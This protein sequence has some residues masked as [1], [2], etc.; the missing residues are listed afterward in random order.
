VSFL[1]RLP[2]KSN[3]KE[4]T[5][6]LEGS[7][8]E[9]VIKIRPTAQRRKKIRKRFGRDLPKE[10]QVRVLR[11]II[12]KTT[13]IFATDIMDPEISVHEFSE[14]YRSRW[15]IEEFFKV[16]KYFLEVENF[17]SKSERGV[18]Q[19]LYAGFLLITITRFLVAKAKIVSAET[20]L[21]EQKAKARKKTIKKSQISKMHYDLYEKNFKQSFYTLRLLE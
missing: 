21:L 13:Y 18:K 8:E 6:F 10:L 5:A 20:R 16:V 12:G 1:M 7:A 3:F 17:H 15:E 14:L 9:A 4:V 2:E 11:K 19:E